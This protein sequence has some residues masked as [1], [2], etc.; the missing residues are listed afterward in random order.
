MCRY[1]SDEEPGGLAR[2]R[3]IHQLEDVA[4]H[5]ALLPAAAP[6]TPPLLVILQHLQG[7]TTLQGQS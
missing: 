6:Q 5:V 3:L 2:R 7:Q 4:G 1:L